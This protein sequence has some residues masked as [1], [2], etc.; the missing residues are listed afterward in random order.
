MQREE[1]HVVRFAQAQQRG[2]QQGPPSQVERPQRLLG[3]QARGFEVPRAPRDAP[4][5]QLAQRRGPGRM[6]HLDGRACPLLERGPQRL[7]PPHQ[8]ADAGP[9]RGGVQRPA[10][11]QRQG[12]VVGA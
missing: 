11:A 3:G 2:P 12:Q 1:Q 8:R 4:Q 5:V 6:D 10:Q 9:Q 7:V